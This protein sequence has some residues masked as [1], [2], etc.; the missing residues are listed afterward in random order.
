MKKFDYDLFVIGAG[1]GGIRAARVAAG[2]N[3][4]VAIAEDKYLGGTCVNVGC[5]PKKLLFYASHFSE[6]FNNAKGFGWTVDAIH[7]NWQQ[8]IKNK[9]AEIRRLHQVY[10]KLLNNTN[11]H[12]FNG[13][14][15]LVDAQTVSVNGKHYSSERILL[16]TGASPVIPDIPGNQYILS[17][18][19]IFSLPKL[20]EKIVI[21]GGGY[22]AT[23]FCSIFHGLGVETTLLYRGPLFLRGFDQD[24]REF[25]SQ[26]IRKKNIDL[27][28]DSSV[29]SISKKND[30]LQI[31][32]SNHATLTSEQIMYATGRN[33]RT[34]Q[35]DTESVGLTLDDNLAIVTNEHY[36]TNVP[37]IYAIGD[38][39]NHVN[40]TPVALAEGEYLARTLYSNDG[41]ENIKPD[42]ENIPTCVFS[43]PNI[44]SVG[45]TEQAARKKYQ[46]LNIYQSSFTPMKH[47]LSGSNEK[48]L[49]KLIVNAD[50]D[51]VI[52][53]HMVG[54]DAGEIIQG[55]SIAINAGVTK[56]ILDQSIGIHP[57]TAEE[58]VSMR[59]PIH[60]HGSAGGKS[61]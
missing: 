28:F 53:V 58:F 15:S 45:P 18:D 37:S 48:T 24:I 25:L 26:E 1:S 3:A 29:Q 10:A 5:V 55:I 21:V 59:P 38:V 51:K 19:D 8:L 34:E 40:L 30:L 47:T 16:A 9:D 36:Q 13:H 6:D 54:A 20:P 7:F 4:R 42:Y 44:G 57:T 52:A 41:V 11:I 12:L 49:L 27:K 56:S 22:I 23:E 39:T 2:F 32:L 31:T 43:Q 50:S 46:Q 17:S 14:A 33:P 60:N 35:L 61:P